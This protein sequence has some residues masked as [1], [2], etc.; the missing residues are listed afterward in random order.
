M[1]YNGVSHS[2][3]SRWMKIM[4]GRASVDSQYGPHNIRALAPSLAKYKGVLLEKSVTSAVGLQHL[5]NI[6]TEQLQMI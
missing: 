3:I 2:T 6:I 4:L 5:P 1:P